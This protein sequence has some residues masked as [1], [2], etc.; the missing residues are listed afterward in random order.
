LKTEIAEAE[1]ALAD[2]RTQLKALKDAFDEKSKEVDEVRR[3]T[4]KA[5][6]GLEAALK[7]ISNRVSI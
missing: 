5:A 4:Q 1:H 2:L 7:E 6:K 3:T